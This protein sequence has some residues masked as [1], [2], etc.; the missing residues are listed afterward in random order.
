M[1]LQEVE[2]AIR[3][4]NQAAFQELG[5][6]F[7]ISRDSD[8]NAFVCTGSQFGKQKTTKGTPDTFIHTHAGKFIMVE[9]STNETKKEKKLIE[10]SFPFANQTIEGVPTDCV[11]GNGFLDTD[12]LSFSRNQLGDF[13]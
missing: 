5:D 3:V 13:V 12:E 11:H 7:M 4:M 8:Y 1:N 6:L 10:P 2:N 9:Y